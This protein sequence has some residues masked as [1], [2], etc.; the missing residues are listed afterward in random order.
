MPDIAYFSIGH[1]AEKKELE[2]I[3][4]LIVKSGFRGSFHIDD[5]LKLREDI[6]T[7]YI[8]FRNLLFI[9]LAASYSKLII[10]NRMLEYAPDKNERFFRKT[11]ALM[12][13]SGTG[14]IWHHLSKEK[15]QILTPFKFF[16]KTQLIRM[17]RRVFSDEL[18]S[19]TYSCY[20]GEDI[21]CGKCYG[22]IPRVIAMANNEVVEGYQNTLDLTSYLKSMKVKDFK[23]RQI[24]QYIGRAFE[25]LEF[26]R[27]TH[28]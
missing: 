17:Y 27:K 21:H 2:I 15:F 3:E 12:N 14:S 22:C 19:E 11:Q 8:L 6:G 25:M 20:E 16:T 28:V 26:K 24:P 18:F 7:G 1:R 13:L 23:F 4:N 5:R 10:I 9:L